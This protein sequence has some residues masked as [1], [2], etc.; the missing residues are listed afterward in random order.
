MALDVDGLLKSFGDD[1]PCG[2]DL[3]YD[4][5]FIALELAAM[6]KEEQQVG[7]S[8]IEAEEP[9]YRE[10][11]E[12]SVKVLERSKDLRAAA[13]Y[14]HAAIKTEGLKGLEESLRYIRGCLENHWDHCHP[15]LDADDDD[16]PTARVN[17]VRSLT[18]VDTVLKAL[19]QT[20]LASSPRIGIFGLRE[21]LISKGEMQA[22]D[23]ATIDSAAISSAFQDTAPETLTANMQS[24][25]TSREHV[26]AI[27][28]VFDDKTPAMGPDMLPLARMLRD[29]EQSISEFG[30][31]GGEEE[32][33]AGG[34]EA[35]GGEVAEAGDGGAAPAG[36]APAAKG[37]VATRGVGSIDG[38]KDVLTALDRICDYYA[39]NEPSSPVPLIL[40]RAHRLV[41]ADFEAIL[42]DLAPG[43]LDQLRVVAGT[44]GAEEGG[45]GAAPAQ[46][47]RGGAPQ[48]PSPPSKK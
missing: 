11:A 24:V 45:G 29:M 15:Q 10:V 12:G 37:A 44:K 42:Q 31:V 21:I 46:G 14:C 30:N 2:E 35:A 33:E 22:A 20:P 27:E 7:N 16:D 23:G 34:D 40:K 25:K 36:G 19:R 1:A 8:V 28:K 5:D 47:Q 18:G 3:E 41:M 39:K 17:A 43:G 4:P 6:P 9:N 26:K 32:A 13:Y 38:R 48:R